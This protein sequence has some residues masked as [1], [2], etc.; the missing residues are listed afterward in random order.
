MARTAN[1]TPDILKVQLTVDPTTAPFVSTYV[2]DGFIECSFSLVAVGFAACNTGEQLN[3]RFSDTYALTQLPDWAQSEMIW[4]STQAVSENLDLVYSVPPREST[5]YDNYAEARGPSPLL[6]TANQT[7]MGEYGVLEQ[8]VIFR[9]FNEPIDSTR[10]SDPASGDACLDRPQLGGCVTGVG[11]TLEQSFKVYT[12]LF[13]GFQP[14]SGWLF[15]VDGPHP[16]P[17]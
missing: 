9:V 14:E 12:N 3:D 6:V 11:F 5:L 17:T 16:L 10:P 8:G 7:T 2:F 13:F 15:A 1:G 4:E